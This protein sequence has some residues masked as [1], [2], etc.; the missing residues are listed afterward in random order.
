MAGTINLL[1]TWPL[2][3]SSIICN[4]IMWTAN[5]L[6]WSI[7]WSFINLSKVLQGRPQFPTL[8][9]I[10]ILYKSKHFIVVNK[11]FDVLINSNSPKDVVTVENQL[12]HRYPEHVDDDT[13][14]GFRFVHRLDFPTSGALALSFTKRGAGWG[15]QVF[16]KRYVTKHYL[17]L[18]R[19]HV[20]TQHSPMVIDIGIGKDMAIEDIN[21]MCT[22]DTKTCSSA[23]HAMTKLV[24]MQHGTYCG[25]PASKVLLLPYTGRTHQLR[26][27]CKHIGHLIVGD[28]TYSDRT[29]NTPYRMMLHAY[30]LV[31]PM[32]H[33]HIDVTAADPFTADKDPE[34]RP[35]KI[36]KNYEQCEKELADVKNDQSVK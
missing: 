13:T 14:H 24:V 31:M 23:R 1:L 18:V 7:R 36:F 5:Q 33:E 35:T 32:K 25:S 9:E 29:D 4:V 30:R 17:A 21:K 16:Q 22:E 19:G 8:H 12:R 6:L 3:V 26:V 11:R 2:I 27:H 28:Y 34:W 20:E 15:S 10:G